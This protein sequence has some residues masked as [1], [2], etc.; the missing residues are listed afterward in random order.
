MTPYEQAKWHANTQTPVIYNHHKPIQVDATTIEHID[1]NK[2]ISSPQAIQNREHILILTPLRDAAPYL[3][4]HFD[5]LSQLTYPHSLIDLAFLVGDSTD[6]TLALLA[7]ELERVQR[8]TKTAF[9][10]TMIVEKDFGAVQSQDVQDRHGFAAQGP[11][12]KLMGKARNYLLSAA[13]RPEHSWVYW[14]DVDIVDSPATIIEDFVA[15]DRDILVPSKSTC[16]PCSG[17]TGHGSCDN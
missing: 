7:R 12:R 14:R 10:S 9:R 4:K 17:R 6:D 15:H 11:R 5:L 2:I 1:L 8:I 13:M 16:I 3:E